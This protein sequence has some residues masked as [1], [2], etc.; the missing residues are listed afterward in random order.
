[1][2]EWHTPVKL[3]AQEVKAF[4]HLRCTAFAYAADAQ[5][6]LVTLRRACRPSS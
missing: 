1:M 5:Q 3:E 4:K 2:H 6:A